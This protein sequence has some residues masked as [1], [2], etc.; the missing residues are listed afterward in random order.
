[1]DKE[2]TVMNKESRLW[3]GVALVALLLAAA[4]LTSCTPTPEV[5]EVDEPGYEV[6]RLSA[7]VWA[8]NDNSQPKKLLLLTDASWHPLVGERM[9]TTDKAGQAEIQGPGCTALYLYKDSGL[10]MSG[11][12]KGGGTG[13]CSTGTIVSKDCDASIRTMPADVEPVGTWFSVTYLEGWQVTLVVVAEGTVRVTPATELEFRL[14]DR[15][16]LQYEVVTRELGEVVA[17]EVMAGDEPRFL[18]TA[19]DDRLK[20]LQAMAELPAARTW[21]GLEELP[22]LRAVLSQ[23]DPN[24][25]PWLEQIWEQ[26]EQDGFRLSEEAP[27]VT[28]PEE[29]PPVTLVSFVD[30]EARPNLAETWEVS[31]DGLQWTFFLAEGREMSDGT[32]YTSGIVEEVLTLKEEGYQRIKG[33]AGSE[34]IDDYT[35]MLVL[36]TANPDF[37][38][39]VSQIELPQ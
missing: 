2:R 17:V 26:A 24:L 9:A 18:Y 12:P 34:K 15:E 29:P 38:R 21:L 19:S 1:M 6:K 33:Y 7:K 16:Q 3:Y 39:E 20:E 10:T 23:R 37:L 11:C 4:L 13:S 28:E 36:E 5:L 32:P 8:T 22:P 30:G 27:P 35:I 25:E 31:E 14:V